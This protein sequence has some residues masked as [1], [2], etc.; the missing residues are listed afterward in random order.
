MGSDGVGAQGARAVGFGTRGVVEDGMGQKGV[1]DEVADL[2]LTVLLV[3]SHLSGV[4]TRIDGEHDSFFSRLVLAHPGVS[5]ACRVTHEDSLPVC[6][7]DNK[8]SV[9]A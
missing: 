8:V 9:E 3:T 6:A 4:G 7:M 1:G 5:D 2:V